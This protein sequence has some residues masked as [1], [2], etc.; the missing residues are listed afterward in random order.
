MSAARQVNFTW[1]KRWAMASKEYRSDDVK[2]NK[3][4]ITGVTSAAETAY[5]SGAPEFIPG[6]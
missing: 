1:I 6:F 4:L 2:L 3:P 5:P